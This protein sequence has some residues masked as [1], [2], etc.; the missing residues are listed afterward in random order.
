[1]ENIIIEK[2]AKTPEINFDFEAGTFSVKGR[3]F[4]D[5][6]LEFFR[7]ILEAVRKYEENSNDHSVV[8]IALEG[9]NTAAAKCLLDLFRVFENIQKR[10]RGK[11]VIVNWHYDQDDEEMLEAGEDYQ[12]ILE[13]IPV[14]L[15]QNQTA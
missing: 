2:T 12:A 9:F 3:L 10:G 7:P 11:S 4:S 15:I 1:M 5:N 8:T 14:K 13:N 6:T